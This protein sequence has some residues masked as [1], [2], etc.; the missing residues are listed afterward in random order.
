MPGEPALYIISWMP[1]VRV[2]GMICPNNFSKLNRTK[3]A[4]SNMS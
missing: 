2:D 3:L 1:G 4:P